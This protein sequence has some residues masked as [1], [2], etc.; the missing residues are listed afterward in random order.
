MGGTDLAA[1]LAE[2]LDRLARVPLAER[3]AVVV[4]DGVT[5][6]ADFRALAARARREGVTVSTMGVGKDLNRPLLEELALDTGGRFYLVSGPEEIPSLL[7]EDRKN[8][9]RPPFIQ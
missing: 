3:H 8:E 7:F 4:S 2:G 5:K 9:A 1:A 6:P